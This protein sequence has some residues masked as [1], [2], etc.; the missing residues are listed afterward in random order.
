VQCYAGFF[1]STKLFKN[2]VA[3]WPIAGARGM[4]RGIF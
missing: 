2:Y 3:G 4:G 1:K